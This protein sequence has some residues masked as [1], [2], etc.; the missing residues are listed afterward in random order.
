[1]IYGIL[2]VFFIFTGQIYLC[3]LLLIVRA[4]ETRI[5]KVN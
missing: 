1:M 2:M 3:P 5:R 4:I